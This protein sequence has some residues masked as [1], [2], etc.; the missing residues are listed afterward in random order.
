MSSKAFLPSATPAAGLEPG[1]FEVDA[2][3]QATYRLPIDV[4]PGLGG[5]QP[6]LSFTYGSRQRNG[7]LGIGWAL[8]GLSAITRTKATYAIDGFNGAIDYG[9]GDRLM[10]DGQRLINVRG[11]YWEP[12][13]L[14]ST[15]LQSWN[16]VLAGETPKEGFTVRTRSGDIH[17]F[18]RTGDSLI[19]AAGSTSVRVWALNA[20]IDRHGN[21]VEYSY[22]LGPDPSDGAYYPDEIR[23]TVNDG[24]QPAR[25]VKFSYEERPDP[26]S[27][28]A[29]GHSIRL[30]QRLSAVTVTCNGQN[31]RTYTLHYRTSKCTQLS[32][33]E[34]ITETGADGTSVLTAA[35]MGWSDVDHPGF[36]TSV[37]S[38]LRPEGHPV[39]AL[40]MSV[41]GSGRTDFVQIWKNDSDGQLH[42]TT[43]LATPANDGNGVEYKKD[44]DTALGHFA[45]DY[46]IL[47]CD[48]TGRGRSDLLV[49]YAGNDRS[50]MLAPFLNNGRGFVRGKTF[51]T[52]NRWSATAH[53]RFFAMDVNGDGRTDL[54]EAYTVDS[55]LAFR[56]YLSLF[57]SD[58]PERFTKGIVTETRDHV[59]TDTEL[60]FWSMD[61][62]GDGAMDLVR[63]WRDEHNHAIADVYISRST[64]IDRCSF[65]SPV[66]SDLG[67]IAGGT[68]GFLPI[69]VNGDGVPDLLHLWQ[70]EA[71]L[72]LTTFFGNAAGAFLPHGVDSEFAHKTLHEFHVMDLDG[73]GSPAVV[74]RG[75]SGERSLMF[76]VFRSSPSGRF[77][78][79]EPFDAG[80]DVTSAKFFSGD[81]NGDGKGD[82]FRVRVDQ[83]VEIVPYLSSG[84]IP[85]LV[86]SITNALGG[87]VNI[88][89]APLTDPSVYRETSD[90]VPSST[91]V[92]QAAPIAPTQFPAE[93]VV[94]Q[95]LYVVAWY[96]ETSNLALNRFPYTFETSLSYAGAQ[97]DLLGRGWQGFATVTRTNPDDGR[98]TRRRYKQNFPETGNLAK[99]EISLGGRLVSSSSSEFATY[100]RGKGA[101]G[102]PIYEVLKASSRYERYDT[103][104]GAFDF[105]LGETFAYDDYGCVTVHAMLGYVGPD[106][107]PLD[108]AEAVYRYATYLNDDRPDGWAL[109]YVQYAKESAN[110]TD[111]DITKFAPGDY[112]LDL[113][114]YTA[115]WDV[116]KEQKW[117]DVHGVWL[118]TSYTYDKYGNQITETSPGGAT[119]V[120]D[121]DPDFHTFRMRTTAP[122]NEQGQTL[123]TSYGFDPRFGTEAARQDANGFVTVTTC[124]AFGRAVLVQGPVPA[125]A[126]ADRNEATPL[127]TGSASLR[128]IFLNAVC[129]TLESNRY[130]DDGAGGIYSEQSLLQSFPSDARRD[131]VW[132]RTYADGRAK[133]RQTVRETGQSG[134]NANAVVRTDYSRNGKVTLQTAPF[135]SPTPVVTGTPYATRT[136]YDVLDRPLTSTTPI[137]EDGH[138]TSLTTWAYAPGGKV[139]MTSAAGSATPYVQLLEQHFYDGKEKVRSVTLDPAGANATTAYRYD[140]IARL[141]GTTDPR[142]ATSPNGVSNTI[143]WDSL[144]RRLSIDNPD[145]NTIGSAST[146]ALTFTYDPSTGFPASQVDAAGATTSFTYDALG[147]MTGKELPDS[148]RIAFTWDNPVA[149]G[150]GLLTRA[151]VTAGGA[152]QSQYDYV[153]D[154]YGNA[155]TVSLTV[156]GEPSPFVTATTCDPQKRMVARTLPDGGSLSRTYAYGQLVS[157]GNG[158]ARVDYPLEQMIPSE[159]P[160]RILFGPAAAVTTQYTFNP[161]GRLYHETVGQAVD[162]QYTYDALDQLLSDGGQTFAYA[163]RRLVAANVPSFEPASYN[164]DA[165]G[166][167]VSKDGVS[168]TYAAHY[169]VRGTSGDGVVFDAAY[170]ACGRMLTRTSGGRTLQFAYD[171]LGC[172][173]R[174]SG[175]SGTVK[176]MLSDA[177]GIRI[178][179]KDSRHTTL[180][181]NAS[182]TV[183][184]P[185]GG[186]ETVT[187]IAFDERGA[188]AEVLVS[189]GVS[190]IRYLR[191]DQKGSNTHAFDASGVLLTQIVYSGYGL[192]H[193]IHGSEAGGLAYEQRYWDGNLGIYYFGARYYDPVTGRF[194]TPDTEA[195]TID[196]LQPDALNR[197]VFELNNPVNHVDADGHMAA[198]VGGLIAGLAI[199]ATGAALIASGG[200]AAVGIWGVVGANALVGGGLYGARYATKHKDVSGGRFWE[201]WIADVGVGGLLA[202][203][204]AGFAESGM[205]ASAAERATTAYL[206]TIAE[207]Q[208]ASKLT[209]YAVRAAV[210]AGFGALGEALSSSTDQF[211]Q[212]AI[213]IGINHDSDIKLGTGVG[214]AARTGAKKG[215]VSGVNASRKKPRAAKK[216]TSPK[217]QSG[218]AAEPE[219]IEMQDM[220]AVR[221]AVGG[222]ADAPKPAMAEM[223]NV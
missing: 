93:A 115:A 222:G 165:S 117:D 4:A 164:Y 74:S 170:D 133:E 223:G 214:K 160:S 194:L 124:D 151:T 103:T 159:K 17:E 50:L 205:V 36:Q 163:N 139:T 193:V 21:K 62:N 120:T 143:L 68:I 89:Y 76:T 162:A 199:A 180:Y 95:A 112:H 128:A 54:V 2:A 173:E 169:P 116:E 105:A 47:P 58:S 13:T 24:V 25:K 53:L 44:S 9:T 172:L 14:Y 152:I 195:G 75:S 31:V 211:L 8:S 12:K 20:T 100:E 220:R 168:Y 202:G 210:Y 86:T 191:R 132:N 98:C 16:H 94:G 37:H 106:G 101:A 221:K 90:D 137:G 104:T 204:S 136:T 167:L 32:C 55:R 122:P 92:R 108:P 48:L 19:L 27:G 188:V 51:E 189:G 18:G 201:G 30:T 61:V 213:E 72:H 118:T 33:L 175:E 161:V 35:S 43:Y 206:G 134:A 15:E 141:V 125:G 84:P 69:D 148:R 91:S 109:G 114:T 79:S 3:G 49:V 57:G 41:S 138:G 111:A 113:H 67:G 40:P 156:E 29:G 182:Y 96:E 150:G 34:S 190:T 197:F 85:D 123:V 45:G 154:S 157:V 176:E 46:E 192:P 166:N 187:R 5:A 110:A 153:Y 198:W 78:A 145:Q 155:S 26:I 216:Q 63:V 11:G 119:T 107:R 171:G 121:Y 147:R 102:T 88:R 208:V 177:F 23:Y 140:A 215:A 83:Q 127:V 70:S 142:T 146:K 179:E 28:F 97:I 1:T 66:R 158:D 82:L 87:V 60:A 212:N 181:V 178:R 10:L 77:R 203:A 207:G 126:Q 186:Q 184:R 129:V 174:V 38:N 81:A 6:S 217:A 218:N 200:A 39:K 65:A 73:G 135:F 52:G 185:V 131:F 219:G 22:T 7:M 183:E 130:A 56:S 80:V 149:N 144:D 196:P 64:A 71:T 99:T 209:L 42:A 59:L